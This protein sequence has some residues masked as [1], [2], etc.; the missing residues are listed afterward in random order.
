MTPKFQIC[1]A[2][3]SD[4]QIF[5]TNAGIG[6]RTREAN[7]KRYSLSDLV[8]VNDRLLHHVPNSDLV[9]H[10]RVKPG[11]VGDNQFRSKQFLNDLS[12]QA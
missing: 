5:W 2:S 3:S 4:G 8:H 9:K 7:V 11:Q 12:I 6:D 10:I 1:L